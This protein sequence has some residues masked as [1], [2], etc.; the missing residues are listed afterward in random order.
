MSRRT[1]ISA[2]HSNMVETSLGVREFTQ[3]CVFVSF[4]PSHL[5][6]EEEERQRRE[7]E[8]R[9]RQRQEE[10]R[11]MIKEEERLKRE[12]EERRQLEEER[13]RVEQQK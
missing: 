9:E 5:R 1:D 2:H 12:E 8:E 10:E 11:R 6:R 3:V 4:L 13:L 7:D